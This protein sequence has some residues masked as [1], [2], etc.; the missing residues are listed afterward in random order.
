MEGHVPTHATQTPC[1]PQH[2]HQEIIDANPAFQGPELH[3]L[4]PMRI[5]MC[6]ACASPCSC[7]CEWRW[8]TRPW[9]GFSFT[10][11]LLERADRAAKDLARRKKQGRKTVLCNRL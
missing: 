9:Y 7:P 8:L 3:P 2:R 11:Q 4:S 6:I 10:L 1:A 5:C